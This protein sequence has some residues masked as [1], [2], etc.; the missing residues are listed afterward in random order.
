MK[1]FPGIM[2]RHDDGNR[3]QVE[4][5]HRAKVMGGLRCPK[6][7]HDRGEKAPPSYS[8]VAS[9]MEWILLAGGDFHNRC[10]RFSQ[11]I[12]RRG[13]DKQRSHG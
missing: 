6:A 12:C 5:A 7:G 10:A 2:N 9:S 1:M 4:G 11:V 13:Y 3:W 8:S